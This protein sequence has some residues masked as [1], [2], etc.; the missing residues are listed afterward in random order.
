MSGYCKGGCCI[1]QRLHRTW[2][3]FSVYR[4]L[5]DNWPNGLLDQWLSGRDSLPNIIT[6]YWSVI[7]LSFSLTVMHCDCYAMDCALQLW[8]IEH[9]LGR[10]RR[11]KALA[12]LNNKD[13]DRQAG[14]SF[15]P[16]IIRQSS[17]FFRFRVSVND[18][19]GG[20]QFAN[21][22]MFSIIAGS[23]MSLV[24]QSLWMNAES[25]AKSLKKLS[26]HAGLTCSSS[27]PSAFLS[28]E[29]SENL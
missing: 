23:E 3:S 6:Q 11:S 8:A 21:V 19:E 7:M 16:T 12:V 5:I 26:N 4:H 10:Q 20:S 13:K 28:R 17:H 29:H 25:H 15:S 22:S 27:R 24:T 14:L 2:L 9:R 18:F 1:R